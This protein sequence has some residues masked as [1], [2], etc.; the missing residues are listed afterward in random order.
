M[1][2]FITQDIGNISQRLA[3]IGETIVSTP[4]MHRDPSD[5]D[6]EEAKDYRLSA[7]IKSVED[8][9]VLFLGNIMQHPFYSKGPAK[10]WHRS[11][12]RILMGG[13]DN[14]PKGIYASKH[15]T[16]RCIMSIKQLG[17]YATN[18]LSIKSRV[19]PRVRVFD[20]NGDI[21]QLVRAAED[22]LVPQNFG[23]TYG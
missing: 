22:C 20:L 13:S 11:G 3:D 18:D 12:G 2:W 9:D 1:K 6:M 21:S 4:E 5:P 15:G 8:F 14:D 23:E 16:P 10:L 17:V 7:L 19:P